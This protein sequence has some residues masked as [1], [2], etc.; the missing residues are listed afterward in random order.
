M[1]DNA[2]KVAKLTI[3]HVTDIY[4]LD[5]F[6][7]LRTL[8]RQKKDE[9]P[10]TITM[11]TG[12]FLAPYLLSSLDNGV[13]MMDMIKRTPIDYL[14][15]GNHEA[16][17]PHKEV[18]KRCEE[19]AAAGGVWINSNMQSYEM[20]HLQKPYE[21][22][23]VESADGSQTRRIGLIAVLTD[24][25]H[26]YKK[27]KPPGAFN[28][29]KIECPW[30]TLRKYKKI[31]EEDE[32]CDLVIPLQ[33]LYEAED[34][35]TLE[36]FDFPIVLSGH[37][38]HRVDKEVQGSRLLKPGSDGKCATIL[39]ISWEAA[40][41]AKPEIS[42]QMVDVADF[43]PD[44]LMS[45]ALLEAY[46]PLDSIKN[47]ELIPVPDHFRP[48]SSVN[49]RGQITTVGLFVCSLVRDS[50]N[51]DPSQHEVDLCMI[52]GGHF[53]GEREYPPDSFFSL[54]D[55]KTINTDN[56]P[57][58][59]VQL[60]GKVIIDGVKSTHNG[61]I[62][63][64]FVQYDDGVK[65][66]DGTITHVAGTAIDANKLYWVATTPTT[67]RDI[68]VFAEYFKTHKQPDPE[69]FIP[70]EVEVL[71][72]CGR[73]TWDRILQLV[74]DHK[75][76]LGEIDANHDGV[77]SKEELQ[78]CM[79]QLGLHVSDTEFSLVDYIVKSGDIDHN[80]SISLDEAERQLKSRN[81]GYAGG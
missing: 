20:M 48:L 36:E 74:A 39:D 11:L 3:I 28:G 16:G 57:V 7:S 44:Q 59:I 73:K 81:G 15:W 41:A 8:V 60:P 45:R 30:E 64:M 4:I 10:H 2:G 13:A 49:C 77:F 76:S 1:A 31:L 23:T 25:W 35:R 12:D 9:H 46:R 61:T 50:V 65:E 56:V 70:L 67:M 19:Y 58:E 29:A 32:Q 78:M 62:T 80:G 33:H 75:L 21:I 79:K 55:L 51:S 22:I 68:E 43:E 72:Y 27:F 18:C 52:R 47:T 66:E 26:L 6:P 24:D 40:D 63:K 54:N 37:D 38:H 17:L 53:S 5:N 42:W 34:Q 14:T 71:A 69:E